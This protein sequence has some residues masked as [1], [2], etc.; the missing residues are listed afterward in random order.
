MECGKAVQSLVCER[1][2]I[3]I[4]VSG[5]WKLHQLD[6]QSDYH[7]QDI[8][9]KVDPVC[10]SDWQPGTRTRLAASLVCA[11]DWQPG[12]RTRLAVSL[13]CASDWQPGTRT[14]L[15]VSLVCASCRLQN[16]T[17]SIH[18]NLAQLGGTDTD[19]A[20]EEHYPL[21]LLY[22]LAAS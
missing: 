19:T 18:R 8:Y 15:A 2:N 9:P 13:V 12:T 10:A 17:L 7:F 20:G 6:E 16:N 4:Q 1:D 5:H 22:I 3:Y 14:R 21:L 11:S